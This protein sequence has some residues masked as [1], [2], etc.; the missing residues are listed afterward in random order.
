MPPTEP[1]TAVQPAPATAGA[2]WAA[3]P[4]WLTQV[5]LLLGEAA[6]AAANAHRLFA[7][8]AA[9]QTYL[10]VRNQPRRQ[11]RPLPR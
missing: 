1:D 4:G 5:D 3:L 7:A 2:R 9:Q 6:A 8:T 11:A 10:T